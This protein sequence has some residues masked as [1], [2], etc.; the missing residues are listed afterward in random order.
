M[1][2]LMSDAMALRCGSGGIAAADGAETLRGAAAVAELERIVE[3]D[4]DNFTATLELTA[5]LLEMGRLGEA[6]WHA[7]NAVRL[8]PQS[9][10]AHMVLGMAL[11]EV[12]RPRA[13]E[14]H[15]RRALTLFGTRDPVAIANLAWNLTTQGRLGDARD[16]YD[17]ALAAGSPPFQT[18]FGYAR[19]E[20]A[21]GNL[22]AAEGLLDRCD[23][24]RPGD[25]GAALA[26][27]AVLRRKGRLDQAMATIDALAQRR[28][29]VSLQPEEVLEKGRLMDLLGR[30]DEA[31]MAFDHAKAEM[32]R[33]SG[34]T[35]LADV[36]RAEAEH[37][38]AFFTKDRLA[39]LPR[40][41]PSS[42]PQPIFIVGFPRSGTTLVEQMLSAH[43]RVSAGGELTAITDLTEMAPVLLAS[44]LPFPEALSELWLAD[45]RDGLDMLRDTYLRHAAREGASVQGKPW[46]TDKMPLN[47]T[48]LGLIALLFPFSPIIHVVR[49]PLDSV[50][51]TFSHQ[52]THG[53]FCAYAL[54]SAA[55]HYALVADLVEHYKANVPVRYLAMRY[56]DIIARPEQSMS[57]ML[58]FIGLAYEP[59]CARPE[60]NP[61]RAP[62]LSY[63][64]VSEP[65]YECS[66]Y[67]HRGYRQHL[68]SIVP[69]LMPAIAQLGYALE[70]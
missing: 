52:L 16:L 37:L 18:L 50:L 27:A 29:G 32:R 11:T 59:A 41:A 48:Y 44:E 23:A 12:H 8:D 4:P 42:G 31:F 70:V 14:F 53:Y 6:E 9:A 2:S 19:L 34:I 69:R 54:E 5:G 64:Q 63:A 24:L 67:R 61:R 66:R 22:T 26:R 33:Q 45:H 62:T 39:A 46:F 10:E 57:E 68:A 28:G 47:E 56:E 49:H 13:G 36:A 17:E 35:Y 3:G 60:Q 15:Y 43:S 55:T 40:A 1:Q 21:D 30:Y 38:R 65:I 51:S 58:A 7:C 25:S 20:E